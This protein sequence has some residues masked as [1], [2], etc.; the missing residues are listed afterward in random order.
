MT[1]DESGE[2]IEEDSKMTAVITDSSRVWTFVDSASNSLYS[3]SSADGTT[4]HDTHSCSQHCL[5]L[6][7]TGGER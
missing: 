4:V 5:V 7:Q 3:H 6:E 1:D 2:S